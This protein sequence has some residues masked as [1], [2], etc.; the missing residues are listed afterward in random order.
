VRDVPKVVGEYYEAGVFPAYALFARNV[1]GLT[2]NNVRFEVSGPE[3]RPAIVLD[4]AHDVAA[5]GLSLQGTTEAESLLRFVESR[6]ILLTAAR[7][8]SPTPV[9]LQVE[10]PG[11]TGIRIDGGDR[12]KAT[13]S[14]AFKADASE[15]SVTV[16]GQ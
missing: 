8:L 5:N 9:F 16:G 15:K 11:S 12:S 2:L 7:V 6:D 10:G 14:L 13:Q 1:R 4:H 3:A